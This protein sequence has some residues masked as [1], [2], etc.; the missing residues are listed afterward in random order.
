MGTP[1]Q[2]RRFGKGAYAP[3]PTA[4]DALVHLREV[5]P[6]VALLAGALGGYALTQAMT[7]LSTP[8][9]PLAIPTAYQKVATHLMDLASRTAATSGRGWHAASSTA[10]AMAT[11]S[12]LAVALSTSR[13]TNA[14]LVGLDAM[15]SCIAI[16]LASMQ[17]LSRSEERRVPAIRTRTRRSSPSLSKSERPKLSSFARATETARGWKNKVE[18]KVFDSATAMAAGSA[19]SLSLLSRSVWVYRA[20]KYGQALVAFVSFN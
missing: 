18:E 7:R 5:N 11:R 19:A 8:T 4:I 3:Q 9:K 20:G 2:T 15:Q 6:E 17:Y 1:P 12:S 13:L 10:V 14:T 16:R